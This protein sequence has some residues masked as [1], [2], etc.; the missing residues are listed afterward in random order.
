MIITFMM[1]VFEGRGSFRTQK[2]L[3]ECKISSAVS[4]VL[5]GKNLSRVEAA[6]AEQCGYGDLR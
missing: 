5:R 1:R 3:D 2:M 4:A 6:D